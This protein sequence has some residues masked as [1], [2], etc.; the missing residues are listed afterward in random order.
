MVVCIAGVMP[1][2]GEIKR[3]V[4]VPLR[5]EVFG[6]ANCQKRDIQA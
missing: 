4:V 3:R 5:G 6:S 1:L 2:T